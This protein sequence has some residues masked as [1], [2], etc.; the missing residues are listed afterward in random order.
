M[1][2]KENIANERSDFDTTLKSVRRR[3]D[4]GFDGNPFFGVYSRPRLKIIGGF[5]NIAV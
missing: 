5:F 1:M 2:E 4:G 3:N